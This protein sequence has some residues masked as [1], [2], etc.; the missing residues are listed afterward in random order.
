MDGWV[1]GGDSLADDLKNSRPPPPPQDIRPGNSS[2]TSTDIQAKLPGKSGNEP[3]LA[4]RAIFVRGESTT[5][6]TTAG[7]VAATVLLIALT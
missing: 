5:V 1:D 2:F 3:D 7:C 6:V 4:D